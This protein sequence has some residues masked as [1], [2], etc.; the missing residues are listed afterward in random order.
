MLRQEARDVLEMTRQICNPPA[1][2]SSYALLPSFT[3]AHA[4]WGS[5]AK[6][7]APSASKQ[8]GT[9]VSGKRKHAMLEQLE[10]M[11]TADRRAREEL[12]KEKLAAR[13][14]RF[15]KEQQT[16]LRT[17]QMELE[18]NAKEAKMQRQHEIEMM[19][20]RMQMQTQMQQSPNPNFFTPVPKMQQSQN[21]S[22]FTPAPMIASTSSTSSS[23]T[24]SSSPVSHLPDGADT[25]SLSSSPFVSSGDDH[26]QFDFFG[27]GQG[28]VSSC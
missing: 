18:H 25:M 14:E 13:A 24:H 4:R 6:A 23:H 10:S 27:H 5:F 20:L 9:T 1:S 19:K 15:K 3:H 16:V 28:S 21:T 22:F 7:P 8:A 12:M 11:A 26:L 17:K 2:I